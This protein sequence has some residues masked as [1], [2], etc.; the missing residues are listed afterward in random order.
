MDRNFSL[1]WLPTSLQIQLD[2][3]LLRTIKPIYLKRSNI[4]PKIKQITRIV[5]QIQL[6]SLWVSYFIKD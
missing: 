2:K 5:L 3:D 6:K 4:G 1:N